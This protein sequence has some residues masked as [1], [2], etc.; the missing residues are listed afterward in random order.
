MKYTVYQTF[1]FSRSKGLWMVGPKVGQFNGGLAHRD[2]NICVENVS[3]AP[4]FK[5]W[6]NSDYII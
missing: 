1:H 5:Y 4:K 3:S 2:D 6:S